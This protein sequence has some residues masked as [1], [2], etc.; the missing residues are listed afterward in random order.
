MAGVTLNSII[1][2]DAGP[3]RTYECDCGCC[4]VH[5]VP[6]FERRRHVLIKECWCHPTIRMTEDG[7]IVHHHAAQ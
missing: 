2:S 5:V 7:E 6:G 3:W 4:D 1:L